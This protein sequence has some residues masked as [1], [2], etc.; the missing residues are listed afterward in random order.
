[1]AANIFY[2]DDADLVISATSSRPN[3]WVIEYVAQA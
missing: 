1:M 2:D 3:I